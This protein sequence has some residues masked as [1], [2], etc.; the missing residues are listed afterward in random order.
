MLQTEQPLPD[1]IAFFLRLSCSTLA[2]WAEHVQLFED[3]AILFDELLCPVKVV[4]FVS[5]FAAGEFI[6]FG[7]LDY[8]AFLYAS[9]KLLPSFCLLVKQ[10][11]NWLLLA[12]VCGDCLETPVCFSCFFVSLMNLFSF[13]HDIFD[14]LVLFQLVKS[15]VC[16]FFV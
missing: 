7:T 1:A 10:T 4:K 14:L 9:C 3:M 6:A 16:R 2:R 5:T 15:L 11:W 13:S 8:P 12:Q